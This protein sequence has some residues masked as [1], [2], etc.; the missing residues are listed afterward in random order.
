MRFS[1]LS[2]TLFAVLATA[3]LILALFPPAV[4]ENWPVSGRVPEAQEVAIFAVIVSGYA[5]VNGGVDHITAVSKP[6]REWVANDLLAHIYPALTGI[7]VIGNTVVPD[8]EEVL[9]LS[10]DAVFVYARD[11]D[12]LRKTG[13][14]R[15]I[16]ILVDPKHPIQ[17]REKVWREMGKIAGKSTRVAAL[18][19]RWAAKRATLKMALPHDAVRRVRV[20]WVF[21]N[22]REWFT[23]NSQDHIAYKLE[24]AGGR[25]VTSD[26]KFTGKGDLEQLLLADPGII[27][28]G[29]YPDDQTIMCQITDRPEFQSLRAVRE[30]RV[31][32]MP[33]HTFMNEPVEDRL[34]LTWMA[35][36]FYPDVMPRRLR[37]EYKETYREVYRYAIS[38][39]EIDKA[40]YL[41]ENRLSA[42]YDR[43]AR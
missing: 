4:K 39:D 37:D 38:D 29:F 33:L 34:L 43:F 16:E 13:S 28:F 22:R 18:L 41:E 1:T 8:P 2:V 9:R 7:P 14:A 12:V 24:L 3:C 23:T 42:G 27:L 20:A 17:S 25:N 19:N 30:G 35:E 10:P 15:L 6:A 40:I 11:A 5:T 32:R 31:Y 36:V 21:A 26:F